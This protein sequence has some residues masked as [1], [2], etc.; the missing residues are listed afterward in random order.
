[1]T[2]YLLADHLLNFMA[3]AAF[4]ALLLLLLTRLFAHFYKQ[5]R[6]A[7]TGWRAE[8]AI[9][10]IVNLLVLVAGLVVFGADGKIASYAALVLAS[11]VSHWLLGRGW[12]R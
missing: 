10:F 4:V 6:P 5:K 11:A 9:I 8:L 3:P 12:Q 7:S 1:M 2:A